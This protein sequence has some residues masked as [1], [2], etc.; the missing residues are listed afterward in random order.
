VKASASNKSPDPLKTKRNIG[1]ADSKNKWKKSI[2]PP[3]L[4]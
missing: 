1:P 3:Q 4:S 2:F